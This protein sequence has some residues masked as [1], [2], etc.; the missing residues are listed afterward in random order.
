MSKKPKNWIDRLRANFLIDS[1]RTTAWKYPNNSHMTVRE[2][3]KN[4]GVSPHTEFISENLL[5]TEELIDWWEIHDGD[6]EISN[7][8]W[9]DY[10]DG[11]HSPEG[12]RYKKII[13]VIKKVE[14]I[15]K[16]ND[17]DKEWRYG[18]SGAP[19]WDSLRNNEKKIFEA[20]KPHIKELSQKNTRSILESVPKGQYPIV[21]SKWSL[22]WSNLPDQWKLALTV[23]LIRL[24]WSRYVTDN[25]LEITFPENLKYYA[26]N[27]LGI[28]A[29][30]II[31][32]FN[33]QLV[34]DRARH[35]EKIEQLRKL[36]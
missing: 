1:L 31:D 7:R 27:E 15:T 18:P 8:T 22:Y 25:G 5:P 30:L 34:V 33:A 11:V 14:G 23:A 36:F 19:L 2:I 24:N 28:K 29:D 17:V 26:I 10:F 3:Y 13:K 21:T 16:S 32:E 6:H 4:H 9:K 12:K 35:K 20:W